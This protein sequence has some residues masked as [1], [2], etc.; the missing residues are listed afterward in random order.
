[1]TFVTAK[2]PTKRAEKQNKLTTTTTLLQQQQLQ[3]TQTTQ[4]HKHKL[5]EILTT[6][7]K[8]TRATTAIN[9]FLH[10]YLFNYLEETV[11]L[12]VVIPKL[13]KIQG[14]RVVGITFYLPKKCPLFVLDYL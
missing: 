9:S 11:R 13:L 14:S 12:Y 4:Q 10:V 3:Q 6:V 5:T 8:R 7:Q 2:H 1:M